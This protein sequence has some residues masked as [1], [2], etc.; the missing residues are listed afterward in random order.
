MNYVIQLAPIFPLL[1]RELRAFITPQYLWFE[2]HGREDVVY[3]IDQVS[4][5]LVVQFPHPQK[6]CVPTS[7]DKK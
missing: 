2:S 3:L 1:V 6:G 7:H 4:G 5:G